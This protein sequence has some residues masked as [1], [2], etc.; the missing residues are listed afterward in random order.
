MGKAD[1]R[2]SHQGKM[3][4]VWTRTLN[5]LNIAVRLISAFWSHDSNDFPVT[6]ILNSHVESLR[7]LYNIAV[8]LLHILT[9][10]GV[11]V[12]GVR[13]T[14]QFSDEEKNMRE[15]PDTVADGVMKLLLP[16]ESLRGDLLHR[17]VD[18]VP[19][20][21]FEKEN[22]PNESCDGPKLPVV[23]Y[24]QAIEDSLDNDK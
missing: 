20:E 24:V 11:T 1:A 16:Y 17:T 8:V 7:V 3:V 19:L 21:T 12:L 15:V 9:S 22:L 6:A 18:S 5:L 10:R 23:V 4:E 14:V 2:R 13:D